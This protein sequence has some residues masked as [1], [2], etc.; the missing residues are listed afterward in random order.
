MGPLEELG[1]HDQR[2]AVL[3]CYCSLFDTYCVC[4]G[5]KGNIV[6]TY[7]LVLAGESKNANYL[8]RNPA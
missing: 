6:P 7:L 1:M 2:S 3:G 8:G 5:P 4:L